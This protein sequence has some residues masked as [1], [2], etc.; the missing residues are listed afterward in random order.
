[1]RGA[2]VISCAT[3]SK[4][5]LIRGAWLPLG[6]HLDLVGGFTPEMREADDEAVRRARV[7]VDTRAGACKEGG[8]I[9]Q[10]LRSGVLA[11]GRH[12]RRSL[13]ADPRHARRAALSRPDHAVQI[14]RHRARG[15]RRGAAGAGAHQDM[16][17]AADT[18]GKP[19]LAKICG[20]ST[21]D[22]VAAALAG[23]AAYLGFVFYPAEP[24]LRRPGQG[25]T[26]SARR[27]PRASS[28]SASSSM[29]TTRRSSAVL[30][31]APLDMLQFHGTRDRRR[32]SPRRGA[33]SAGR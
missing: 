28:A 30:A 25:R 12:R 14:G 19:V 4:E 18:S 2:H 31:L 5:P 11:R 13:R 20:L 23:G 21:P 10:P 16:T 22:A 29:P 32:A 9:V 26:R 6:A 27:C 17:A 15:S 24:A 7:F 8:D 1:M 33:A 3:L